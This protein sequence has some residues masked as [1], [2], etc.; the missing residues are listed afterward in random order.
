[1]K[2][3]LIDRKDDGLT[4][5]TINRPEKLN[6]LNG[7]TILELMDAFHG[8][9]KDDGVKAV[10][11][12]GAGEK[13]FVAGADISELAERSPI[14]GKEYA[15]RGQR[16]FDLVE[17]LGKPVVAAVNGFALG[18]GMELAMA[19]TL[20]IA[21]ENAQ[22][23]QPE[24]LLEVFSTDERWFEAVGRSEDGWRHI[25]N[26]RCP[27]PAPAAPWQDAISKE[28]T[29]AATLPPLMG[30]PVHGACLCEI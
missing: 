27:R 25:F 24:V 29:A 17:N 28:K 20:R 23:G 19:C 15:L 9:L 7:E 4:V 10:I 6:A 26:D 22:L 16:V 5:L 30:R 11:V 18:G 21:S 13:A 2:N 8:F 14:D 12:T 1:M 3:L